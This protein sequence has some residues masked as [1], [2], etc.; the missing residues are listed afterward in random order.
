[1]NNLKLFSDVYFKGVVRTS[2]YHQERSIS[3]FPPFVTCRINASSESPSCHGRKAKLSL[4]QHESFATNVH[5]DSSS[6][7]TS[8]RSSASLLQTG[9]TCD[10]KSS[11]LTI[12]VIGATGELARRKIF[13]ALFALYYS[14]FLPEVEISVSLIVMLCCEQ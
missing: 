5:T 6:R 14:G 12:A 10:G 13:P 2:Q 4:T 7:F 8:I 1:M 3:S 11:F 9:T